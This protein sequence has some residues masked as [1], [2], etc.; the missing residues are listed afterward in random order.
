MTFRHT[1]YERNKR[2]VLAYLQ[3]RLERIRRMRWEFGSILP[4]EIKVNLSS[5][6]Y[7]WFTQYSK[8]LATY[9]STIGDSGLNLTQDMKPPKSLYIE[10]KC[11]VDF[12]RFELD[13]GETVL[14]KKNGIHLL[15]RS[16]CE[17]LIRQGILEHIG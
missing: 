10:V 14:L 8:C 16:Q 3:N 2:C 17:T 1:A 5:Y 15:P 4:A 7:E 9:M 13:T 11:L 12:G 6:E